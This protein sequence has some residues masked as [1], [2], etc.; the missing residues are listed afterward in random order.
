MEREDKSSVR[1]VAREAGVNYQAVYSWIWNRKLPAEKIG[2]RWEIDHEAAVKFLHERE[3]R[4][5]GRP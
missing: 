1:E 3:A 4:R 2:G 5:E